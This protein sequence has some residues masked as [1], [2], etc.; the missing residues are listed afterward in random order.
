MN[1]SGGRSADQNF[2]FFA[3]FFWLFLPTHVEW[4]LRLCLRVT[5]V[6]GSFFGVGRERFTLR[7]LNWPFFINL[8]HC[9][10]ELRHR[11]LKLAHCSLLM[12]LKAFEELLCRP[13]W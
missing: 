1:I 13:L 6:G 9:G 10:F 12:F 7:F 5:Y 2:W 3:F 11:F 8:L 4:R